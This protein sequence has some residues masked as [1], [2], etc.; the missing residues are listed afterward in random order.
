MG[1]APRVLARRVALRDLDRDCVAAA[2][3]ALA[4]AAEERVDAVDPAQNTAALELRELPSS[5]NLDTT[6]PEPVIDDLCQ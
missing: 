5:G 3:G 4:L 6:L 2:R 1:S